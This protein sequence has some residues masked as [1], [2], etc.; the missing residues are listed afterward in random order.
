MTIKDRND[1]PFTAPVAPTTSNSDIIAESRAISESWRGAEAERWK[2]P[3]E[4]AQR[5]IT[6]ALNRLEAVEEKPVEAENS[7][8]REEALRIEIGVELSSLRRMREEA[9]AIVSEPISRPDHENRCECMGCA[10]ED[11]RHKAAAE[12]LAGLHH[13]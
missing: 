3:K 13:G 1:H 11:A 12:I 4:D 5:I 10:M 2:F 7:R 6:G 8:K 9:E